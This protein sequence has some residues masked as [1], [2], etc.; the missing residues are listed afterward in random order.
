MGQGGAESVEQGEIGRD[1]EDV[2]QDQWSKEEQ[3]S[4]TGRRRTLRAGR[5]RT[6]RHERSSEVWAG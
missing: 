2:G 3:S 5:G 1:M 6:V 4:G